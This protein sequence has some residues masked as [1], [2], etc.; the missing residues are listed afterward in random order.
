MKKILLVV[1]LLTGGALINRSFAQETETTTTAQN[2]L[3]TSL[4]PADGTPAIFPTQ[5]ELD[6]KVPAKIDGIKEEILNNSNDAV[7]V[8]YLREQLWRF[9]NAVVVKNN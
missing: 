3:L 1:A 6:S 2:P 5:E 4:K 9:E 7:R 8:K